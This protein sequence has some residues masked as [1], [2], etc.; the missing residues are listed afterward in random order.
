ML[1]INKVFDKL[2]RFL[3]VCSG[4]TLFVMMT[5]IF[6]DVFLRVVIK[7]PIKGT[8]EL[9][10]EYLMVIL[11]YFSISYTLKEQKHVKVDLFED[12]LPF[13]FRNIVKVIAN[14][15]AATIFTFVGVYNFKEGINYFNENI[16][17]SGV[18]NYPLAP[19]LII[20]SIGIFMLVIR[21]LL[22]SIMIIF[23]ENKQA[24]QE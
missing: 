3:S 8:V 9:T 15:L 13:L 18:L 16:Q 20:I 5:W 6:L 22:E 4:I 12:K 17:S 1:R 11:V 21:L 2:D 10:G 7:T 23:G 14:L 24:I 19:A